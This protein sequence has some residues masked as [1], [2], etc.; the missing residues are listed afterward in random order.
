[1]VIPDGDFNDGNSN[2]LING[3]DSKLIPRESQIGPQFFS[4]S[5][6]D[7]SYGAYFSDS[8]SDEKPCNRIHHYQ[9]V[10]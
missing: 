7:S 6:S 1:M 9:H 4:A 8:E 10:S 5:D 2:L 3:E